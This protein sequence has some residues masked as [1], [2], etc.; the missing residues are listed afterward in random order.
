MS[1]PT[2]R[3]LDSSQRLTLVAVIFD[4]EFPL[5]LIQ[6]RSITKFIDPKYIHEVIWIINHSDSELLMNLEF[7]EEAK[8]EL[9]KNGFN[10]S[11]YWRSHFGIEKYIGD[12][13]NWKHQQTLKLLACSFVGTKHYMVLDT[14]NFFV[15]KINAENIIKNNKAITFKYKCSE[16]LKPWLIESSKCFDLNIELDD[17]VMPTATPY[18]FDTKIVHQLLNYLGFPFLEVFYK[19]PKITE[20][21]SYYCY[22]KKENLIEENYEFVPQYYATFFA[23]Y[24]STPAQV[25]AILKMTYDDCTLSVSFHRNRF[26]KCSDYFKKIIFQIWGDHHLIRSNEDAERIFNAMSNVGNVSS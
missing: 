19:N 26:I 6:S 20:F 25:E 21:F 9:K 16:G 14:K 24:P 13:T 1:I 11:I 22:L 15:K 8:E 18:I 2:L 12:A 5:L 10:L 7:F 17:Y 23:Q 4:V 3:I